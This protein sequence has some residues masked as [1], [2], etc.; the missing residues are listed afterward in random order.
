MAGLVVLLA[1]AA[2]VIYWLPQ[3]PIKLVL[4]GSDLLQASAGLMA[5]EIQQVEKVHGWRVGRVMNTFRIPHRW[6]DAARPSEFQARANYH[7]DYRHLETEYAQ[8][9]GYWHLR[10]GNPFPS[11]LNNDAA[12]N[13]ADPPSSVLLRLSD[14]TEAAFAR[15]LNHAI[16]IGAADE[17]SYSLFK[18]N[19]M[20]QSDLAAALELI[21][22]AIQLNPRNSYFHY[23]RGML[24]L[25]AG[26]DAAGFAALEAGN[27]CEQNYLPPA[28]PAAEI[29]ALDTSGLD[30]AKTR[31]QLVYVLLLANT[32]SPDLLWE[33]AALENVLQHP[34]R[35]DLRQM[36]TLRNHAVRLAAMDNQL[37]I[38]QVVAAQQLHKIGKAAESQADRLGLDPARLAADFAALEAAIVRFSELNSNADENTKLDWARSKLIR[39]EGRKL[40]DALLRLPGWN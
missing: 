33:V 13:L 16:A 30:H 15:T 35:L 1:V 39:A 24:L 17:A 10:A 12:S 4:P 29:L 8:N 9:P 6:P 19:E 20:A 38:P 28:F 26:E 21:E 25:H 36:E 18:F 34:E 14:L 23:Q 32:P 2:V 27:A 11:D 7:I 5:Q 3:G 31:E 37:F 22:A 40:G